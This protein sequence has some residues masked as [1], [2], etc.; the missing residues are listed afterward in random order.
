MSGCRFNAT[1]GVQEEIDIVDLRGGGGDASARVASAK[2]KAAHEVIAAPA[3][4][5]L[6]AIKAAGALAAL[7]GLAAG[8]GALPDV[9]ASLVRCRFTTPVATCSL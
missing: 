4:D 2:Q 3:T 6:V 8:N 5:N 1:E 7:C 9:Q